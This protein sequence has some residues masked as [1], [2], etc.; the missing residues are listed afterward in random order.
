[1]SSLSD[2]WLNVVLVRYEYD[3]YCSRN[4]LYS[5][6]IPTVQYS[7]GTW[8]ASRHDPQV[9]P[10][11]DLKV[12][13]AL[14][15]LLSTVAAW[16]SSTHRIA[17]W[18]QPLM[19]RMDVMDE[20]IDPEAAKLALSFFMDDPEAK[21]TPT[22]GGVNN[23]VQYVDTSKGE[24]FVLR[25]YNNGGET[26]RVRYEHSVLEQMQTSGLA[27]QLPYSL[28][29]YLPSLKGPT[30]V[31]MPDGNM[32]CLSALIP[33]SL[34]KTADPKPLGEAVG[35]LVMAMGKLD[36]SKIKGEA[37]HPYYEIYQAHP[38]CTR[39]TFYEYAN[40]P[41]LDVC[42]EA[43]S[44]MIEEFKV[45]DAFIERGLANG[46]P[47]QC[48]HGDLHYDNVLCDE[49]TGEVT[50]LLDFEFASNDWRAMELAVCLSKYVGEE[51]PFPLVERFVDGFCS[52][53]TLTPD[54][55]EGLPDMI[56]MRVMSNCVYFVGRA[57][58][59]E[60]SIESLTK[61]ADMYAQRMVWV[62]D[63]REKI[64]ESIR[65]RLPASAAEEE[66]PAASM[67]G[68]VAPTAPAPTGFVWGA[69]Y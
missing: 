34:P 43:M 52:H 15:A 42:R 7:R 17:P 51:D 40:G 26:E 28:P 2:T 66:Q 3:T 64:V 20:G 29:T 69:V 44:T 31:E 1:M 33:G 14:V 37:C 54:E 53:A 47:K 58:A 5:C 57:I 68:V 4:Y 48:V 12:S 21:I 27:A 18:R 46:L 45:C 38:I 25:V 39:E 6:R 59:K 32:A 55:I 24:R 56:N 11:C 30:M 67:V 16:S 63:N 50:G 35:Q 23:Y 8:T 36:S 62:R 61:R 22:S 60:D 13:M 19:H 41:E 10:R 49:S 65:S 9:H